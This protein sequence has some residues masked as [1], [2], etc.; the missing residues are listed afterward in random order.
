MVKPYA[1]IPALIM[2]LVLALLLG[3]CAI[4]S[5]LD[6]SSSSAPGGGGNLMV[7]FVT[8][9]SLG[10][11]S[12]DLLEVAESATMLD[13]IAT[14]RIERGQLR[15]EILAPDGTVA[16]AVE[17]RPNRE[18]VGTVRVSSDD[19]GRLRYRVT[20]TEARQGRYQI[21]YRPLT[22]ER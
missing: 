2:T 19:Q 12:E 11:T 16:L 18:Q 8:S 6:R 15:L 13:V 14:V 3:G 17:G 20:T 10:G 4:H 21:M 7:Q 22:P 5:G 1:G 9:D